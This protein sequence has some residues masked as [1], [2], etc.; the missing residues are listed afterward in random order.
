MQKFEA[1]SVLL[2]FLWTLYNF[3]LPAFADTVVH[4][5]TF[6][7]CFVLRVTE[8]DFEQSCVSKQKVGVVNGT[9]SGPLITLTEGYVSWIRVYNDMP[10]RNLTMVRHSVIGLVTVANFC[11]HSI[12]MAFL[13]QS[14]RSLMG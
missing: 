8:E 4:N 2:V 6:T 13:W 5:D 7:P 11:V 12:G 1:K 10:D 14:V 9:S 3:F